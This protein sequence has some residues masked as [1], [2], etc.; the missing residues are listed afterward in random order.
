M[1]KHEKRPFLR[2]KCLIIA[3]LVWSDR[4]FS[5]HAF[6]LYA[7]IISFQIT[8]SFDLMRSWFVHH[9]IYPCS[10]GNFKNKFVLFF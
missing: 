8:G 3:V 7:K 1:F 5:E 4:S 2:V 10:L 6:F 9:I